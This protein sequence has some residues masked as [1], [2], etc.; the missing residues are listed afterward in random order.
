MLDPSAGVSNAS[1]PAMKR[2]RVYVYDLP[3]AYNTRMVQYRVVKVRFWTSW[4]RLARRLFVTAEESSLVHVVSSYCFTSWQACTYLL[5]Q[6]LHDQLKEAF[7][8]PCLWPSTER[9][10]LWFCHTCCTALI[11]CR[12]RASGACFTSTT[13]PAT[14]T[15][16]IPSSQ[17][18]TSSSC[19][20]P[21]APW[22][23][24]RRTSSTCRCTPA[25]SSTLCWPGPTSPSGT[26]TEVRRFHTTR[27]WQPCPWV[28]P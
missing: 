14:R 5:K 21:T 17:P 27:H 26:A 15:G 19:R 20:A 9:T 18:C 3:A 12:A 23:L 2:P 24:T 10:V 11:L 28:Q 8:D 4:S 25:A 22:I 13:R 7:G 6:P 16:P 1:E